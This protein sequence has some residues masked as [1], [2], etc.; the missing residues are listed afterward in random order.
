MKQR[1][2]DVF[3]KIFHEKQECA[4]CGETTYRLFSFNKE[5]TPDFCDDC[6][7]ATRLEG[8]TFNVT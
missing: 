2:T 8:E 7:N 5:V 6:L 4:L 3:M 1:V